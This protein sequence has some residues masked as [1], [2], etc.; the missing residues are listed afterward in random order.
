MSSV[1]HPIAIT[2]EILF[3]NANF[4]FHFLMATK[5]RAEQLTTPLYPPV[6][7]IT[8][9]LLTN[10]HANHVVCNHPIF[11]YLPKHELVI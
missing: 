6:E 7:P 3:T 10:L 1:I 8:D 5:L 4:V 2:S 9:Y 11:V